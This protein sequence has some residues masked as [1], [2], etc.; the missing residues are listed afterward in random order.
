MALIGSLNSGISGLQT[1]S[2]D[3]EVIGNNISNVNTT[4][5]KSSRLSFAESFS[6][7][8]RASQPATS[9]SSNVLAAQVGTGVKF[10]GINTCYTQGALSTTGQSTDLGISGE[11]YFM[12]RDASTG[13]NL[14]DSL[15]YATRVGSFRWDDNGYLVTDQGMRV[16]DTTGNDIQLST[17]PA[18]VTRESVSINT[19]G[20]VIEFF[21]DGTNSTTSGTPQQIGLGLFK[22]QGAL[23][24]E[25]D[26]L[27]TFDSSNLASGQSLTALGAPGADGV[28]TVEAGTLEQSNVDLTSEF[29]NMITAQ[30]SFQANS[31]VVTVSDTLLEDI[32]NLKR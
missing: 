31:R 15:S 17:L 6:N 2:K 32:V 3:L 27:Y 11:G 16:Q 26:G 4:A 19:A 10:S 21:S 14:S 25:G 12:V 24:R 8:L 9:S 1:F 22:Q 13:T 23:V 30:R 29:A 28:G 7:T 20:Q 18:G 5:Y